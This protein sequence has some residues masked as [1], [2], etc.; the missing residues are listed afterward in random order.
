MVFVNRR[1]EVQFLS[2]APVFQRFR[3]WETRKGNR[4]GNRTG[5]PISEASEPPSAPP[6]VSVEF[7]NGDT[8]IYVDPDRPPRVFFDINVIVGFG[9]T[10]ADARTRRWAE[11]GFTFRSSMVHVVEGASHRAVNVSARGTAEGGGEAAWGQRD[12]QQ[13]AQEGGRPYGVVCLSRRFSAS[14]R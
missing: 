3:N 13:S 6:S 7:K 5:P 9:I 14:P 8:T 4:K 11:Y 12:R 2:P 1:L 10:G